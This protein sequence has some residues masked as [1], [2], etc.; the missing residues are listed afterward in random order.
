MIPAGEARELEAFKRD[1]PDVRVHVEDR[2]AGAEVWFADGPTWRVWEYT[3][4]ALL[5]RLRRLFPGRAPDTG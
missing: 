5:G 4:D 1:H 3:L 2:G